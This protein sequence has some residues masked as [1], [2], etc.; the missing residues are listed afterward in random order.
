[1]KHDFGSTGL[2]LE[3]DFNRLR[4]LADPVRHPVPGEVQTVRFNGK[5]LTP[6]ADPS[7][8][9][10]YQILATRTGIDLINGVRKVG[11][12][13]LAQGGAA[14]PVVQ[15]LRAWAANPLLNGDSLS[16]TR[17]VLPAEVGTDISNTDQA[18]SRR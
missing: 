16:H 11:P 13:P 10:P 8:R 12:P 9:G 3:L 17:W 7:N 2:G 6:G 14:G 1:V 5:E 4:N 18:P 15:E